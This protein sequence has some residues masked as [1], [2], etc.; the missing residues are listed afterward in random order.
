MSATPAKSPIFFFIIL[1]KNSKEKVKYRVALNQ[2]KVSKQY[3]SKVGFEE[4]KIK[5]MTP[6]VFIKNFHKKHSHFAYQGREK[7]CKESVR[8]LARILGEFGGVVKGATHRQR[9]VAHI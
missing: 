8:N 1:P 3:I 4:T 2:G 6:N 9:S 5:P 7:H